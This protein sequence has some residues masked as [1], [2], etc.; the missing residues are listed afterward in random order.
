MKNMLGI[1]NVGDLNYISVVMGASTEDSRSQ[2]SITIYDAV[3][4][5]H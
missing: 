4:A 3:K 5:L 2:D 1:Y